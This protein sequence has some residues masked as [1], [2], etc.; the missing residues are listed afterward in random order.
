[1]TLNGQNVTIAE[2][3][4]DFRSPYYQRQQCRSMIL[5]S[6]NITYMWIFAG[7]PRKGGV[8]GQWVLSTTILFGYFGGH[9]FGNLR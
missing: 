7:A 8:K 3:K 9:F 1:M 5:F 2:I 6:R 4:K